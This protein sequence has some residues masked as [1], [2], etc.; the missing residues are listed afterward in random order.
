LRRIGAGR[1]L[2]AASL[3]A[4]TGMPA[5]AGG[6]PV[7]GASVFRQCA[8]CHIVNS[9]EMKI[10]PGLKGL[11][12]RRAGTVADFPYSQ[13]MKS[14]GLTWNEDTLR[15][16]LANPKAKV[17]GNKMGFGGVKDPKRLEDL[18]AYLKQATR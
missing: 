17:P 8:S 3:L 7:A 9:T 16:Y 5:F 14:S 6:D 11:F 12:G 18:L 10:G 1:L 4:A 2:V 15:A 13:A